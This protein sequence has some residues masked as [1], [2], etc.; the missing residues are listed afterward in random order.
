MTSRLTRRQTLSTLTTVTAT[1]A[2]G[3]L[4]A[5]TPHA[6]PPVRTLTRGPHYHWFGYYDKREFDPT[7][8][9]VLSNEVDFEHR[10]P[11]DD[12]TIRVG[13][14]DTENGDEWIELGTSHA[15]GWQQGCMLQWRRVQ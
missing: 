14:V 10:T 3:R 2:Q 15:W 5:K 11:R 7:D 13:M 12:D 6:F 8:R 9:F 1:F 4:Y